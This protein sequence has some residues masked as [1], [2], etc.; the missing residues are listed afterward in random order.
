VMAGLVFGKT[1][2]ICGGGAILVKTTSLRLGKDVALPDILG[3]TML[4]GI[5]FTVSLLITDLSFGDTPEGGAAKLAV[6]T[7][8]LIAATLGGITLRIR[9]NTRRR[10]ASDS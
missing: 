7:G 4:A 8:S 10:T 2:G 9:A 6:I 5:G 3:A 1:L